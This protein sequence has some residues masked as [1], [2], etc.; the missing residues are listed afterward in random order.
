MCSGGPVH[1]HKVHPRSPRPKQPTVHVVV[2]EGDGR[3]PSHGR[4][5]D[6]SLGAKAS[7]GLP[8]ADVLKVGNC[9]VKL[10]TEDTG[11]GEGA[12]ATTEYSNKRL[13]FTACPVPA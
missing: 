2:C 9:V 13:T 11:N 4:V 8:G 12:I 7:L 5:D 10:W 1:P 3:G 6:V